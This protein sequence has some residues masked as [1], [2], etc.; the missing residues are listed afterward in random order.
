MDPKAAAIRLN[1]AMDSEDY[2]EAKDAYDDLVEWR[3][4]GGDMPAEAR[5][6]VERYS[7]HTKGIK[8]EG[9]WYTR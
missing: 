3:N 2:D 7:M 1:E 9:H 4:K 6:A 5:Q 8:Q